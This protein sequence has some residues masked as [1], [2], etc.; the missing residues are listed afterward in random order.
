MTLNI[1]TFPLHHGLCRDWENS[2]ASIVGFMTFQGSLNTFSLRHI[3]TLI[4]FKIILLFDRFTFRII[5]YKNWIFNNF[6]RTLRFWILKEM[7]WCNR[8][9]LIDNVPRRFFFYLVFGW[10]IF[11][12]RNGMLT[13]LMKE[14]NGI[15]IYGNP[16]KQKPWIKCQ[17]RAPVALEAPVN[18]SW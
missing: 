16:W 14:W 2:I 15:E 1:W 4:L 9:I 7:T 17:P 11:M 10:S 8:T 5:G 3:S 12:W 13:Q 18:E 6:Q